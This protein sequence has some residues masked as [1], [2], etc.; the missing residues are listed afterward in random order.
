MVYIPVGIWQKKSIYVDMQKASQ[1]GQILKRAV[2][3]VY[4]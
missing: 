1:I 2:R 3:K 4:S